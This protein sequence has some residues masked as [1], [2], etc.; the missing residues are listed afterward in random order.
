LRP[1]EEA[2]CRRPAARRH[3]RRR[4]SS[5]SSRTCWTR[6][7]SDPESTAAAVPRELM[8]RLAVPMSA[9]LRA[10]VDRAEH[11]AGGRRSQ[12]RERTGSDG[13]LDRVDPCGTHGD[14]HLG[15][16][17]SRLIDGG[18]LQ[19][20]G[21]TEPRLADRSHDPSPRPVRPKSWTG[22]VTVG[23]SWHHRRGGTLQCLTFQGFRWSR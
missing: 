1:V 21:S 13:R 20:L 17:R 7:P 16:Q 12:Q 22:T 18:D 23:H 10:A 4:A 3:R 9:E 14:Q 8:R 15:G 19:D 2:T 6:M 11:S 5:T